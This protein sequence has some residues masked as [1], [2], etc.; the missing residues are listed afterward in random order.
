MPFFRVKP[1]ECYFVYHKGTNLAKSSHPAG[2]V[3]VLESAEVD[4]SQAG[5][6][7]ECEAEQEADLPGD[8]KEE[9]GS[10]PFGDNDGS[11]ES[12]PPESNDAKEAAKKLLKSKIG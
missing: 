1:Y 6:L 11:S 3:F 5:K 2:S 8:K 12:A 7:E 4:P 9:N 10:D